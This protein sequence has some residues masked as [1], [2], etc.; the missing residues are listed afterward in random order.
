MEVKNIVN[1]ETYRLKHLRTGENAVVCG[2]QK[3]NVCKVRQ[4][5]SSCLTISRTFY[6]PLRSHGA[7]CCVW[8]LVLWLGWWWSISLAYFL[9]LVWF[10]V[11]GGVSA[12]LVDGYEIQGWNCAARLQG[13][14]CIVSWPWCYR[15]FSLGINYIFLYHFNIFIQHYWPFLFKAKSIHMYICTYWYK[16]N[17]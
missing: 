14:I 8:S 11:Y 17:L 7:L 4:V 16:Q 9:D 3:K 12:V 6:L 5:M 15:N 13:R 1:S 2:N 10:Q